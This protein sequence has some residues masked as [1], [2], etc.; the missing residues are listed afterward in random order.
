MVNVEGFFNKDGEIKEVE[1]YPAYRIVFEEERDGGEIR[2][3]GPFWCLVQDYEYLCETTSFENR[4]SNMKPFFTQ[5]ENW[6]PV[7]EWKK[8]RDNIPS[9]LLTMSSLN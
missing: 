1:S 7:K 6:D 5:I 2:K 4:L 9:D 3:I 8:M